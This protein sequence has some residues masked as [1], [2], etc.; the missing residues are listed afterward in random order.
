M[1]L[2][3]CLRIRATSAVAVAL[4]SSV[5]DRNFIAAALA[6]VSSSASV[7]GEEEEANRLL[8]T[9]VLGSVLIGLVVLGVAK[10]A[11]DGSLPTCR[12]LWEVLCE[13]DD[14]SLFAF[15]DVWAE[16]ERLQER[17]EEIQLSVTE[18]DQLQQ[19]AA[20]AN[21]LMDIL[22]G[23]P[24][25]HTALSAERNTL[26]MELRRCRREALGLLSAPPPSPASAASS[27]ASSPHQ[28]HP[29]I[30]TPK[31]QHVA[32]SLR[33]AAEESEHDQEQQLEEQ[34]DESGLSGGG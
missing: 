13:T 6:Q 17:L 7:Y 29:A 4:Y 18:A 21:E 10:L 31:L 16:L 27:Y 24:E 20:K 23:L 8:S 28:S 34:E 26:Y 30:R 22:A 15:Q 11:A 32:E 25:K 2:C 1:T 19:V 9:S 5:D 14:K 12:E 33:L 3:R